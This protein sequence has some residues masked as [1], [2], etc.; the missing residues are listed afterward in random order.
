MKPRN[1]TE[2][3]LKVPAD[4]LLD[5]LGIIVKESLKHE[6]TQVIESRSIV[7]VAVFFDNGTLKQ[8]RILQNIQNIL[9]EYREYR[10]SNSEDINWREH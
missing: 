6:I 5:I 1:T 10:W 2:E 8:Q 7:V 9:E 4:V 3:S